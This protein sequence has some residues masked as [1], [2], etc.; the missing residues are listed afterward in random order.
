MELGLR[1]WILSRWYYPWKLVRWWMTK[2]LPSKFR[3]AVWWTK[4]LGYHT[5]TTLKFVI[6]LT[7]L[8]ARLE[9]IGGNS[10]TDQYQN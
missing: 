7:H 10:K 4:G 6:H 8:A 3:S 1:S 9:L 2:R 5:K